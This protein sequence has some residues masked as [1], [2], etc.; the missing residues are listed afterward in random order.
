MLA[1]QKFQLSIRSIVDPV[2]FL[3]VAEIAGAK[4]YQNVFPV[5]S[6]SMSSQ[7]SPELSDS[8]I[9]RDAN[10]SFK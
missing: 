7:G 3:S 10:Q 6:K 9:A 1:K 4:Q 8:R 5:I 2:S